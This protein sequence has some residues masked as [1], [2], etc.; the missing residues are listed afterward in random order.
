L[1]VFFLFFHLSCLIRVSWNATTYTW[2][3]RCI[4]WLKCSSL[5]WLVTYYCKYV[6]F[7]LNYCYD[8]KFKRI[9]FWWSMSLNNLII[10]FF[11]LFIFSN[12]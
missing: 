8:I 11:F 7:L 10:I 9:L 4:F 12:Y 1:V 5:V 2:L 6:I 3:S